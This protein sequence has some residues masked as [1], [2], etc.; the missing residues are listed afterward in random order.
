[1]LLVLAA[2]TLV[3]PAQTNAPANARQMSLQEC[4]QE[5]L[6]HNLDIQID[7]YDPQI[8]LFNLQG[9][10]GGYD[11]TFNFSGE[12]DHNEAGSRLL[13][14]GFTI[15][16]SQ[17]DADLFSS[18]LNGA[19]PWGMTYSLEGSTA[20][21][22]GKSFALA[23]NNAI[24]ANGFEST[25]GSAS[26]NLVQPLL[27]NF[28]IDATRL[29]IKVGKNRLKYSEQQLRFQMMTIITQLEQ[30]YYD[31]IYARE[32][33]VVQEKAVELAQRLVVENRKKVEVGAM[34][35]LDE[36]QAESQAATTRAALLDAQAQLAV[37]EH[38]VK[39][40]I[41]ATYSSW[42]EV[43]IE[44]VGT[45]TA[46]RQ[47]F[48]LHDSW[49]KGLSLRPDLQALKLNVERVGIQLKYDKNQ[50]FPELDLFGTYGYNGSGRE[51]SDAFNDMQQ[52]DRPFYT[53]GARVSVPLTRTA[54]RNTYRA[55]KAFENQTL[56]QMKN[57]E[58]TIMVSI[59]NDIRI[60][61]SYYEQVAATRS[62]REYQEAALDAEQKK[63]ESGK[64]TTYTVLQNQRDLTTARGNEIQ[65]LARYNKQLSQL[66]YDEGTTF[67]R[68]RIN[69]EIK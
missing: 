6:K 20:D 55:D 69:V 68:L 44:P 60:A 33:V 23:T 42:A 31:L 38:L 26:L 34:A 17:S 49:S 14:G 50:L 35:P 29:N 30:A 27:K 15:P 39:K 22:Y 66:S 41:T 54:S 28:W 16:G 67:D 11:P 52:L 19:T 65:A 45:L 43:T 21:T 64:S 51:F 58:Q 37:Q 32:Y 8:A 62:A 12:R 2:G 9:T 4:I 5:A 63:L 10:Y 3:A 36:Q 48:N 47:F 59:D 1:M 57:L 56:L 61:Q 18:S 7:R 24:F 40:L 46:P 25:V 53:A 13:A